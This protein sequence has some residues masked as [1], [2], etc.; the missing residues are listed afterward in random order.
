VEI[1][2]DPAKNARNIAE[3][4]INFETTKDFEFETAIHVV[5]DR[6][7]YG[8]QRWRSLGFLH[9]RLHALVFVET[10]KGIRVISFRKANSREVK[11][12]AEAEKE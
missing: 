12:Y 2:Y 3:R 1:T 5:D 9:D 11:L 8:E 4:G 7:D 6:K 10:A